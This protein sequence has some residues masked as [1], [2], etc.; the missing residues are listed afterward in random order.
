MLRTTTLAALVAASFY[1]P[2]SAE[3]FA[4]PDDSWWRAFIEVLDGD[5]L[6]ATAAARRDRRYLE[7]DEF[8]R[9]QVLRDIV[10]EMEAQRQQIDP[11]TAVVTLPMQAR[12]GD[13]SGD[14][15]GFPVSIF[16]PE[17]YLPIAGGTQLRFRN[18][19]EMAFYPVQLEAAKELRARIGLDDVIAELTLEDIRPSKTRRDAYDA[20]VA[21][22]DYSTRQGEPLMTMDA[23]PEV[24]RAGAEPTRH[25]ALTP[26]AL[27]SPRLRAC[28]PS[29]QLGRR[30]RNSS[31]TTITTIWST[32]PN[33]IHP[34]DRSRSTSAA[35]ARS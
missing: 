12:L 25:P 13:Y 27:R 24:A 22:V 30:R 3:T 18:A 6:D 5:A 2:A 15:G 9:D 26:S 20:H 7:A 14:L 34:W 8:S 16:A 19:R 1:L 23:A 11:A 21:R 10:A 17:T 35:T 4:H 29:A 28:R 33:G 32:R 31:A